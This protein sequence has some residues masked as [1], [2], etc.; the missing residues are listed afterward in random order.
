MKAEGGVKYDEF[1]D[2]N[3]VWLHAT[4]TL[5]NIMLY[6]LGIVSS[7]GIDTENFGYV[8]LIVREKIDAREEGQT[9]RQSDNISVFFPWKK[10][11]TIQILK[12]QPESSI[13][14]SKQ[15]FWV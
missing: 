8:C 3:Y 10:A 11:L 6:Y 7:M 1:D 9:Y 14:A 12:F 2:L 15:T 5:W 4:R 13:A